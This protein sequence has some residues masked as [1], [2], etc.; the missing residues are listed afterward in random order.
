MGQTLFADTL[1]FPESVW[2]FAIPF[3][4]HGGGSAF[5]KHDQLY[6]LSFN[7]LLARGKT[8]QTRFI[9]S[10]IRKSDMVTDTLD[11]LLRALAWSC[12]VALTGRTPMNSWGGSKGGDLDL[13]GGHR[14]VLCQ[15]RSDWQWY[16]QSFYF[17]QRNCAERM[18][19][20]GV[21]HLAPPPLVLD[22]L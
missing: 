21:G 5:S 6:S 3:G 12:N 17:P 13:R 22:G 18:C 14:R 2:P 16:C 20:P 11:Q 4:F 15:A 19:Q 8:I 10:V 1:C 9:F 7:S